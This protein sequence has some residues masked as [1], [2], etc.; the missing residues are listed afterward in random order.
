MDKNNEPEYRY[1]QFPLCL[2]QN[3]IINPKNVF[4]EPQKGF[5]LIIDY[6]IVDLAKKKYADISGLHSQIHYA[7]EFLNVNIGS[8]DDMIEQYEQAETLIRAHEGK[9]GTD[10]YLGIGTSLLFEFRDKQNHN[11]T[12][13]LCALI[14]IRS[15]IGQRKFTGTYKSVILMRM[16]GA[17]SKK[18]LKK[19]LQQK[20]LKLVHNKYSKRYQMDKLIA[21]LVN[22]KFIQSKISFNRQIFFSTKLDMQELGNEIIRY[23]N[24]KDIKRKEREARQRIKEATKK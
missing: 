9:Y 13:L 15:L 1:F 12:E 11:E 14:A 3:V 16:I 17:K 21:K 23:I 22:R 10:P 24:N 6:S 19:C 4:S 20:T 2:L 18:A 7:A 5:N 8:I